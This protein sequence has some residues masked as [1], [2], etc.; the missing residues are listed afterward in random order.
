MEGRKTRVDHCLHVFMASNFIIVQYLVTNYRHGCAIPPSRTIRH[1]QVPIY[2]ALLH[3]CAAAYV[4]VQ[5]RTYTRTT[6]QI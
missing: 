1:V 4:R 2:A 5:L 6:L 3:L